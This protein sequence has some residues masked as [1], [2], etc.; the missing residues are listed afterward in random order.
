MASAG[1]HHEGTTKPV[2]PAAAAPNISASSRRVALAALVASIAAVKA[3]PALASDTLQVGCRSLSAVEASAAALPITT[4]L[5][6]PQ[7]SSIHMPL[8]SLQV[9]QHSDAEWRQLLSPEAYSVLRQAQTERRYSS[10]LV[11]VRVC[12]V[13]CVPVVP[14]MRARDIL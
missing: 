11:D 14:C 1:A 2:T 9:V 8:D 7:S 3:A 4:S 10:P 13:F 6:T 5:A 12:R